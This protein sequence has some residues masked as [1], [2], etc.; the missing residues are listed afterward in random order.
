MTQNLSLEDAVSRWLK[1]NNGP[2]GPNEGN[3]D[4]ELDMKLFKADA[5]F[6]I[7]F[8]E[9][10]AKEDLSPQAIAVLGAGYAEAFLI[11]HSTHIGELQDRIIREPRI[12]EIFMYSWDRE[13][14]TPAALEFLQNI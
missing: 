7:D 9:A 11:E 2:L 5:S 8:F 3:Y 4:F 13:D 14:M 1:W 10:L 12:K 6:M